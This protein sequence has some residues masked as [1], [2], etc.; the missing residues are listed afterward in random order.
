MRIYIGVAVVLALVLAL[1]LFTLDGLKE[2]AEK[3]V[4]GFDGLENAIDSGN[5]DEAGEGIGKMQNMWSGYKGWWA[6]VVDHQEI[7]NIDMALVRVSRY[8]SMHDRAMAAGELAVLRQML[9]HIPDKERVN[10]KNIF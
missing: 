7:D 5:W 3:M 1:G 8:V 6:M 2:S 10:L 4:A 9:E